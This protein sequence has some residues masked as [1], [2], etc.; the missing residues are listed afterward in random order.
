M[1]RNER[2]NKL[3]PG[4]S[5]VKAYQDN[6]QLA[7]HRVSQNCL[8]A[9]TKVYSTLLFHSDICGV[10]SNWIDTSWHINAQKLSLYSI[11]SSLL[12][13]DLWP[14]SGPCNRRLSW[15]VYRM[16]PWSIKCFVVKPTD[17]DASYSMACWGSG[18][19]GSSVH[20]FDPHMKVGIHS[21]VKDW[22][23]KH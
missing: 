9:N 18:W 4:C 12:S 19:G 8:P 23:V 16:F 1:T 17:P 13:R 3:W 14:A 22:T 20:P 15:M 7:R 10:H 2:T 21:K 6:N 11:R 5:G